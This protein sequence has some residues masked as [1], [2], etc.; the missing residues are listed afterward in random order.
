MNGSGIY[1]VDSNS[2]L[3]SLKV[4]DQDGMG[5]T[6]DVLDAIA[7]AKE[8]SIKVLNLSF[9]GTGEP[10]NNPVCAAITDAKNSGIVT[11][12]SAG[13]SNQDASN[14]IPAA[15]SDAITVGAFAKDG[16]KAAFSNFGN[17]V[18]IY[19]PG[20]DIYTT[21]LSG[22]YTTQNGTSFSAPFVTGLVAK[23]LAFDSGIAYDQIVSNVSGNYGLK[24][25]GDFETPASE[26]SSGATH[27]GA[28]TDPATNSGATA[29]GATSTGVAV[30]VP[31]IDYSAYKYYSG[32]FV[33]NGVTYGNSLYSD[34]FKLSQEQL[35]KVQVSTYTD[36]QKLLQSKQ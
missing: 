31:P 30:I 16:T 36:Y 13:N 27:T 8:N 25:N 9:G 21:T 33:Q 28:T 23:E 20:T 2:D 18:D 19:A 32:S 7:Y 12:V 24:K 3:V 11:V 34:D 14:T 29:T 22:A 10:A 6:Y 1:G 15:C 26:S 17:G 5:T 4:L 35:A